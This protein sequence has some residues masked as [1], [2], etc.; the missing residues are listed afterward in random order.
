MWF[1]RITLLLALIFTTPSLWA[2]TN[3]TVEQAQ[4]DEITLAWDR[5]TTDTQGNPEQVAAY[6][7]YQASVSGGPYALVINLPVNQLP[8]PTMP[9][10]YL[11][12]LGAGSYFWVVTA[13]DVDGLESGYSNEA[14][15]VIGV[16]NYPPTPPTNNRVKEAVRD[17]LAYLLDLINKDLATAPQ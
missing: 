11:G 16:P 12:V 9:E 17:F 1:S 5:V 7:I 10:H 8:N 3:L 15:I 13:V 14:T 6:R 2:T 4:T